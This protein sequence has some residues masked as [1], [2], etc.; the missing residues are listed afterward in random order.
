MRIEVGG[1]ALAS[2]IGFGGEGRTSRVFSRPQGDVRLGGYASGV[3]RRGF[4]EARTLPTAPGYGTMRD[5]ADTPPL[6]LRGD[7]SALFGHATLRPGWY[8]PSQR[9]YSTSPPLRLTDEWEL[10]FARFVVP[11][12]E[13]GGPP[14][15]GLVFTDPI[16]VKRIAEV[17][18]GVYTA[19]SIS[20]YLQDLM[21]QDA[22]R[23]AAYA[24]SPFG[25]NVFINV[26]RRM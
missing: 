15:Q 6:S 3:Q 20:A 1:D 17:A 25:G 12:V 21:N 13:E 8:A 11:R 2:L 16:G 7:A 23:D 9:I 4:L 10:Q 14:T 5:R 18:P 22:P 24:S 26:F 19:S